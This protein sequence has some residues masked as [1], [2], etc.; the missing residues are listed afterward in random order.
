MDLQDWAFSLQYLTLVT[1]GSELGW[2]YQMSLTRN[3]DSIKSASE[4]ATLFCGKH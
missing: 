2:C 3:T 4:A 1:N